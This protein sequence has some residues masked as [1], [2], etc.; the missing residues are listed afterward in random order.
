MKEEAPYAR[1][2]AE[3]RRRIE[4]GELRPGDRVPSTR[5]ITQRW[6][7]AMATASKVLAALGQEGLV[8]A[9]PGVGTVVADPPA[10]AAGA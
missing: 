7:V 5:A 9:V 4:S 10:P 3:L 8:R 2:A 1:I 6:G